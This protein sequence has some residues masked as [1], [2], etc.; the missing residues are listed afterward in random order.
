MLRNVRVFVS[1]AFL[2][3]A[4]LAAPSFAKAP[5]EL[6]LW[7]AMSG[8][9]GDELERLAA[10]FNASQAEYR[11]APRYK[12]TEEQTLALALGSRR[13]IWGPHIVQVYEAGTADLMA[14]EYAARPLWQV[15]AEA[16]LPLDP[17][18]FPAVAGAFSDAQGRLLALPFNISTPVLYYNRV[19]FRKAKLDAGN[20]PRTWYE[21]PAVLGALADSGSTCALTTAW[22][23]WILLENMSAWHNEEFATGHNGMDGAGARLAF[24]RGL[25]VRW[26]SMLNSWMKAGYFSYSG[27]DNEGEARFA[28]GECAM[29]TSS[30][31]SYAQLLGRAKFDVGVAQLPYYDDFSAAP[32]NTL[33]GGSG[34][35]VIAGRTR[36][37]YRGVARF[38]AYLARPD[39]QAQ[40]H[41][42]TGYLPLTAAAYELGRVQGFYAANPA[43]EIAVRQLMRKSPTRDTMGIRLA[44]FKRIRGIID[45]ELES[46][47]G[48]TKTPLDA[49]NTAVERGNLLLS[50]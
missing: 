12:G 16:G 22:Q 6:R 33:V 9:R 47:W 28:S 15:M 17:N 43:Q 44:Q 29:L 18:Y 42:K 24:N 46:V 38:L 48:G 10:R 50:K 45:E 49:L 5:T 27:R 1:F 21:M 14:Q 25:M 23:S 30:S 4:A 40:W 31:A 35:W 7:H 32:Q 37:E 34:L 41:Q 11:V 19:A 3:C 39:V 36:W 26:I 20:P 8:A 13:S 2:L